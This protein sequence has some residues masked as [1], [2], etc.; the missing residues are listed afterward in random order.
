MLICNRSTKEQMEM[1]MLLQQMAQAEGLSNDGGTEGVQAHAAMACKVQQQMEVQ[2]THVLHII[3]VVL[4]IHHKHQRGSVA[5]RRR[6]D[7]AA[8]RPGDNRRR[9]G[10]V[11]WRGAV[12]SCTCWT[13]AV[14]CLEM[15]TYVYK[16]WMHQML[17]C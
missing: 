10:M 1:K 5:W 3:I 17:M 16:V 7:S 13:L 9:G 8:Q 15:K 12:V 14:R 6:G 11:Q 2:T 4:A